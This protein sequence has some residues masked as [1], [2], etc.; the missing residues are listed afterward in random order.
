LQDRVKEFQPG[1]DVI[2]EIAYQAPTRVTHVTFV[3]VH[4]EDEDQ[5]FVLSQEIP[6]EI[7][8]PSPLVSLRLAT[9][10]SGVH[11]A[12]LYKLDSC[13]FQTF[14][15]KVVKPRNLPDLE[16]FK[17]MPE[18]DWSPLIEYLEPKREADPSILDRR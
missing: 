3:F 7:G 8:K 4:E 11:K 13:Q 17:V 6:K 1:E 16:G 12:G 14:T 10:V 2:I 9:E 15:G 18:R 5:H